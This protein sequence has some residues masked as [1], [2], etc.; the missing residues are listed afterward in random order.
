L[1]GVIDDAYIKQLASEHHVSVTT[2][3]L[4]DQVAIVQAQNNLGTNNQVFADVLKEF[5]GWS[6]DD[7]KRELKQQMLAQKVVSTLDTGT[8][9]RAQN[10]LTQLQQG[11][12]FGDLA[13]QYSDE[14]TS[15]AN[16]GDYGFAITKTNRDIPPQVL[17]QLF[18]LKAGQTSGII[19]AGTSLEIVQVKDNNGDTVHAS[20]ISFTFKPIS[21]YTGPLEAKEKPSKYLHL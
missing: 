3:E 19:N 15:G 14:K 21:D 18:R 16:G 4:N 11:K 7:F 2:Q 10:V 8:H 1:Q 13:K 6:I 9:D 17:D 12:G 5:W 20:H